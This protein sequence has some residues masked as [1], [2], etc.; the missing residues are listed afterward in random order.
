MSLHCFFIAARAPEPGEVSRFLDV[1]G[2][3]Q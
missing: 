1:H 2:S 3:K